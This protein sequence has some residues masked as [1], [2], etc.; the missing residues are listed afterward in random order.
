M[1]SSRSNS[2]S[3]SSSMESTDSAY[4]TISNPGTP[5]SHYEMVRSPYANPTDVSVRINSH[6]VTTTQSTL[7]RVVEENSEKQGRD[8][9]SEAPDGTLPTLRKMLLAAPSEDR[10]EHESSGAQ[11]KKSSDSTED[12]HDAHGSSDQHYFLHKKLKMKQSLSE[13]NQDNGE[14]RMRAA[15][16]STVVSKMRPH[17]APP[18]LKPRSVEAPPRLTTKSP[19]KIIPS[20][21]GTT[22]AQLAP[23]G[24]KCVPYGPA[25]SDLKLVEVDAVTPKRDTMK[26]STKLGELPATATLA[27]IVSHVMEAAL[28]QED[29]EM[30]LECVDEERDRETPTNSTAW[31]GHSDQ[32]A[33]DSLSGQP[34]TDHQT[35]QP[36][37]DTNSLSMDITEHSVSTGTSDNHTSTVNTREVAAPSSTSAAATEGPEVTMLSHSYT[38]AKSTP[39][40]PSERHPELL[41]RLTAGPKMSSLLK[42]PRVG[43]SG[44]WERGEV[45]ERSRT[46]PPRL[47]PIQENMRGMYTEHSPPS[48][49]PV[50]QHRPRSNTIQS[51]M[52]I[53]NPRGGM[54]Q[55]M[56]PVSQS[57]PRSNTI[58]SI[59]RRGSPEHPTSHLTAI[60]SLKDKILK[61]IDSQE[62]IRLS[63]QHAA[64]WET[65]Q[66][67]PPRAQLHELPHHD[68][69]RRM[70]HD[71]SRHTQH[72][73]PELQ[74]SAPHNLSAQR[75][76]C[77]PQNGASDS[78]L[79]KHAQPTYQNSPNPGS[80]SSSPNDAANHGGQQSMSQYQPPNGAMPMPLPPNSVGFFPG[81]RMPA[82]M[83]PAM[84][85]NSALQFQALQQLHVQA[86]QIQHQMGLISNMATINAIGPN[87]TATEPGQNKMSYNGSD[88]C[89][90]RPMPTKTHSQHLANHR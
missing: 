22:G 79:R 7:P 14:F 34:T 48:L 42:G 45:T 39:T 64:Q 52:P 13:R 76:H 84:L 24:E 89:D 1:R 2:L 3:S 66:H 31:T 75:E 57:R 54:V 44:C 18:F 19:P 70:H 41:S 73:H 25:E 78:A 60:S 86:A 83:H 90:S 88:R 36:A 51:M 59:M 67:Q 82:N 8:A 65:N 38:S 5:R 71:T 47:Y 21:L 33:T 11:Q 23:L 87:P 29:D 53:S 72:S 50:S 43:M 30:S 35:D 37:T 69:P 27:A 6:T 77:M 40:K 61:R 81:G 46:P 80:Q 16:F 49:Q 17:M 15:S 4:R 74:H 62:N 63:P 20:L 55:S 10:E 26:S 85:L 68:A 28:S 9:E 12:I 32:P 58:Q 56:M